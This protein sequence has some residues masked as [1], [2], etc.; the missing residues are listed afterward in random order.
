MGHT[1]TENLKK[2]WQPEQIKRTRN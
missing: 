2:V 1:G